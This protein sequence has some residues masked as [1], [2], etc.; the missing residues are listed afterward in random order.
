MVGWLKSELYRLWTD[1]SVT[2]TTGFALKSDLEGCICLSISAVHTELLALIPVNLES[3]IWPKTQVL[4][5][6]RKFLFC[7]Q[8]VN[9]YTS[10][11]PCTLVFLSTFRPSSK[12]RKEVDIN[13]RLSLLQ[14]PIY[15]RSSLTVWFWSSLLYYSANLGVI[16]GEIGSF[17]FHWVTVVHA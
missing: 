12:I 13:S 16:A 8:S 1:N 4:N 7:R 14:E 2:L 3:Q 11:L 5:Y 10:F 6:I 15:N 9:G 17:S